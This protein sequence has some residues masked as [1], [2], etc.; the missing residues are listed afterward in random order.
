[1]DQ[2][3]TAP[4]TRGE[5]LVRLRETLTS[6]D[7]L[8]ALVEFLRDDLAFDPDNQGIVGMVLRQHEFDSWQNLMAGVQ[9]DT[10]WPIDYDKDE[11]RSLSRKLLT[12]MERA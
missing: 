4:E 2:S 1:M 8:D 6:D 7:D 11:V 5:L 9:W 3:L 12:E 10:P